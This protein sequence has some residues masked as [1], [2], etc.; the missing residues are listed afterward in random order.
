MPAS[1]LGKFGFDCPPSS[2]THHAGITPDHQ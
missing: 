2:Y 1:H